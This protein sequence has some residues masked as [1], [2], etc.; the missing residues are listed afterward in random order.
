MTVLAGLGNPEKEYKNTRHNIGF[1]VIDKISRDHKIAISRSKFC[2]RY[3]EGTIDGLKVALVKPQSY[4]NLSG[5]CL[6]DVLKFFKLT[7]EDLIVIY[8]DADIA[9]GEI[10]VRE[11]GSAGGHNGMKNVICHL[12]TEEF[13]RVRVGIGKSPGDA[14]LRDYVLGRISADG[15]EQL[16]EGVAKAAE[17]VRVIL[18]DGS[19]AAMNRFN[20]KRE[21]ERSEDA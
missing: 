3:G 15:A 2:A 11:R 10:R 18:T 6:R 12:G 13:V 14:P 16:S 19:A 8:D 17:A 5:E 21:T 9:P 4:M 1:E 20:K 7:P